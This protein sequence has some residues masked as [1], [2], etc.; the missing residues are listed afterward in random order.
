MDFQNQSRPPMSDDRV[1]HQ[2]G[3][4]D[5]CAGNWKCAQCNSAIDK[6]PFKPQEDRLGTLKCR[7]CFKASRPRY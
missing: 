7:N 5:G 2:A 1:W 6:L 4:A 3:D